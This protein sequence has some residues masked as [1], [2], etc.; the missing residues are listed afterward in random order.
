MLGALMKPKVFVASS[1]ESLDIAFAIQENLDYD[2]EVTVW[3]QGVFTPSSSSLEALLRVLDRF[4]FGAFV[5]SPDDVGR[6][7]DQ[8]LRM[9]RDNVVFELG[10]FI[11]RL[12]RE[13][14]FLVVPRNHNNLHFPTDLLGMNPTTFNPQRSDQ[15]L[16]AALGPACNQ[17]RNA[18]RGLGMLVTS[19]EEKLADL[20][21]RSEIYFHILNQRSA[22]SLDVTD[23][24]SSN[25]VGIQQWLYHAG[26]N[27][28]WGLHQADTG[29]YYVV[30]KHS[31]KYLTVANGSLNDGAGIVQWDLAGESHQQWALTPAGDGSY[32]LVAK[33]SG[34]CL[35]VDG[36]S[37]GNGVSVVQNPMHGG[38]S[39]RWWINVHVT[40]V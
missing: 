29:Y 2:A 19:P 11:S 18:I 8:E 12:G 7:R 4:D 15:N 35:D 33:H 20:I 28:M 10:L 25:G 24:D 39:Q 36:A 37:L 38:T 31:Q 17:I 3:T 6:I 22:K 16:Q 27:Q 1:A 26:H 21:L 9:V 30:S 40:S 14:T 23:W 13:R 32:R 5:F 34:K